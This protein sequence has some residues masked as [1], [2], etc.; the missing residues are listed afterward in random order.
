MYKFFLTTIYLS[1]AEARNFEV[2]VRL[3]IVEYF[4]LNFTYRCKIDVEIRIAVVHLSDKERKN[5][6]F[7][8]V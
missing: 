5:V 1:L 3:R 7:V 8:N 4:L 2:Y 6:R